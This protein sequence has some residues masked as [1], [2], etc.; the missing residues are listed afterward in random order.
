MSWDDFWNGDVR[1]H[2]AYREAHKIR[3]TETNSMHWLQGR[4]FFDALCAASPILR[5]FSKASKPGKYPEK[6]YDLFEEERKR[7]EEEEQR[8]RY[9][10]IREKVALFA[11]EFNKQRNSMR[12]EV[13]DTDA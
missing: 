11:D 10:R 12:K 9:E 4:Y 6:P 7:R 13:G 2:R 1:S 5:A 3:V 8:K